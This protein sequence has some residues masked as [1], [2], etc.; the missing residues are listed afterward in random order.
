MTK[1]GYLTMC[2]VVCRLFVNP[3]GLSLLG[4]PSFPLTVPFPQDSP[5]GL[6]LGHLARKQVRSTRLTVK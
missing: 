4:P 1:K 3:Q 6:T 5:Q 2:M